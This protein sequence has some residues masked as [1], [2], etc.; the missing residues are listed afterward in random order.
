MHPRVPI[1][2]LERRD[3]FCVLAEAYGFV[4]D[5]VSPDSDQRMTDMPTEPRAPTADE[6]RLIGALA[7]LAGLR[8]DD[9]WLER[10]GVRE[11][12]DGGMGSLRLDPPRADDPDRMFDGS[13]K[14]N[15]GRKFGAAVAEIQFTDADG[16]EVLATLNVDADGEPFE[17]DVWKTDFNPLIRIPDPL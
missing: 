3:A 2:L 5:Q 16:V 12:S 11:M 7:R 1:L 17:L 15:G 4:V 10:L 8:L 6:A 14:G 9:G 13:R